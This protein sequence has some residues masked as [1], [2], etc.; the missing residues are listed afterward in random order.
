VHTA[1]ITRPDRAA[2]ENLWRDA[3]TWAADTWT[4]LNAAHFGGRL[5]YHGI[6]WGLTPHGHALAH[7]YSSGRITLHPALL[8]PQSDDPWLLEETSGAQLGTR[9]AA[10]TL[11]HEMVHVCLFD[12]D[13][14][15]PHHNSTEWCDEIVRITPQLGLPEI[16]AAPVKPRRVNRKVMRKPLDGHLPR[17]DISRWP[18]PLR[19]GDYYTRD[20]RV[21]VPI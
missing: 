21:R 19:T 9:F 2:L 10:D 7:T 18:H 12:R 8:N 14:T 5:R 16:K 1:T 15:G 17:D 3:G 6:V 20:G 4:R 11:L 13:I